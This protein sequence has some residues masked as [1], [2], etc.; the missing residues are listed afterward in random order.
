MCLLDKGLGERRAYSWNWKERIWRDECTDDGGKNRRERG[1]GEGGEMEMKTTVEETNPPIV[2]M[3]RLEPF[4][5]GGGG[6]T[7][8]CG[9]IFINIVCLCMC[10]MW[11]CESESEKG[12]KNI[13]LLFL[14]Y[15]L[16]LVGTL[17]STILPLIL[18]S[19]AC[20]RIIYDGIFERLRLFAI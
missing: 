8:P 16:L 18:K 14:N 3:E 5:L 15:F 1:T 17:E 20:V 12:R 9:F 19:D 11:L 6:C 10:V 7:P 13:V 2:E 4:F